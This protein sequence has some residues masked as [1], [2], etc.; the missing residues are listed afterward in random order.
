MK[1]VTETITVRSVLE[2]CIKF[3]KRLKRGYGFERRKVEKIV[4]NGDRA[5]VEDVDS[6]ENLRDI[7]QRFIATFRNAMHTHVLF[8]DQIYELMDETIKALEAQNAIL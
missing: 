8:R 7:L 4:T 2:D 5:L 1:S 6:P 3:G